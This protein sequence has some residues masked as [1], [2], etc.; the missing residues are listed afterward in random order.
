MLSLN[1]DRRDNRY[2]KFVSIQE[3]FNDRRRVDYDGLLQEQ[4]WLLK[5]GREDKFYGGK[6]WMLKSKRLYLQV[7]A[8]TI[9][10]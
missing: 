2:N 7:T 9:L 8:K 1:Q 5:E 4:R 10:K 6:K 3:C